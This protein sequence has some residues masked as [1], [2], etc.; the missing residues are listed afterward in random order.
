MEDSRK[1]RAAPTRRL[2]GGR[3]WRDPVSI[4][5]VSGCFAGGLSMG[6]WSA[7]A[8][9]SLPASR[10]SASV[11]TRSLPTR[12]G[13][14]CPQRPRAA[15]AADRRRPLAPRPV[16]LMLHRPWAMRVPSTPSLRTRPTWRSSRPASPRCARHRR[17]R[18]CQEDSRRAWL[19]ARLLD[20]HLIKRPDKRL[21][22]QGRIGEA[23]IAFRHR[24][25][26]RSPPK[27]VLSTR[28]LS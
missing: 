1:D 23:R 9:G 17:R 13:R 7:V 26:T 2:A 6:L 16:P 18:D 20:R 21:V 22:R 24:R 15:Q 5:S 10:P 27:S 19:L 28:S 4:A 3:R 8:S 14:P 25:A 12:F 11:A